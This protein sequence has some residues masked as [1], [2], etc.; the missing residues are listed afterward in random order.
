MTYDDL[1]KTFSSSLLNENV[2]FIAFFVITAA[3]SI[4]VFCMNG[5][6]K[7]SDNTG[8]IMNVVF[9]GCVFASGGIMFLVTLAGVFFKI[10]VSQFFAQNSVF[11]I[12]VSLS[13]VLF[14]MS[15]ATHLDDSNNKNRSHQD[16]HP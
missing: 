11:S 4:V 5:T 7:Y 8:K 3:Y 16:H 15:V 12:F 2:V 6:K 9:A 10:D 14:A 13:S 1:Q